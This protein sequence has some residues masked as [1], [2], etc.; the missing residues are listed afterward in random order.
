VQPHHHLPTIQADAGV[1]VGLGAD[2]AR[3]REHAVEA[4]FYA[5]VGGTHAQA[6]AEG[7]EEAVAA[8]CAEGVHVADGEGGV[9]CSVQAFAEFTGL[10]GAE[11]V[12]GCVAEDYHA[13]EKGGRGLV[14]LVGWVG[15]GEL[16]VGGGGLLSEVY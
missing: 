3:V 2:D 8:D 13:G 9:H 11:G 5:H 6:L 7:G 10:E 16:G 14:W 1:M 4:P 15:G 12:V